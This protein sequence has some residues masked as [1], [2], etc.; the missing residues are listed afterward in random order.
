MMVN[1]SCLRYSKVYYRTG[2]LLLTFVVC[3]VYYLISVNCVA[4][5]VVTNDLPTAP[6]Q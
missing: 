3:A 5:Y 1:T 2:S 4:V 6:E